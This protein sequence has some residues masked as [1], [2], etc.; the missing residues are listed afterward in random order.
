MDNKVKRRLLA[1]A[2]L[3]FLLAVLGGGIYASRI[4]TNAPEAEMKMQSATEGK[5]TKRQ[6]T[7][8]EQVE[9]IVSSMS[10]T[11]KIGQ[12]MMI[13]VQGTEANEDALYVLHQFHYGGIIL[14]DR[15]LESKEQT[16]ALVADLQAGADEKLPMFVAIDEEGGLVVRGKEFITPPPSQ[17][18][19]GHLGESA[20]AKSLA[21]DTAAELKELGINVNLAP[22]VDVG[23]GD[24]RSYS[25]EPDETLK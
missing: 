23:S 25:K 9:E 21:K 7:L 24:G 17:E 4:V 11:E 2:V 6:L 10:T 1:L 19:V 20:R 5:E 8:D 12:L 3:A 15:N 13:G 16:K 18:K 22:V 14:F